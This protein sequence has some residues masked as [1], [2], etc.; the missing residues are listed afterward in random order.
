MKFPHIQSSLPKNKSF[1]ILIFWIRYWCVFFLLLPFILLRQVYI[2]IYQFFGSVFTWNR[3]YSFLNGK[4]EVLYMNTIK[5]LLVSMFFGERFLSIRF[6]GKVIDPGPPFAKQK[7]LEWLE[8]INIKY[9]LD[10]V[11][12][13]HG[14][15]EH[16]GNAGEVSDFFKIPIFTS[17]ISEK[18]IINPDKLSFV[19]TFFIGQPQ[20][21]KFIF[22][23]KIEDGFILNDG[24][25]SITSDGH[26]LGHISFYDPINKILFAGD[27]FLHEIFT[28]PNKES[29]AELWIATLEKYTQLDIRVMI[30][31]HG[32]V[33]TLDSQ[34]KNHL[35]VLEKKDPNEMIRNK[36][37]F[38]NWAVEIV[39]EGEKRGLSYKI[40]EACLFPWSYSWSWKNWFIDEGARFFSGGEFS[41]T[42]F[43]RSLASHPEKVPHRFFKR[44]SS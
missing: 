43:L 12:I 41:R 27:S 19:R 24:V 2:I 42:Q 5:S 6:H 38:I 14:H 7:V 18:T 44:S 17:A 40:I 22:S 29:K 36:L 31:S 32:Y 1:E 30:G 3:S 15:E 25:V 9:Q 33:T 16:I 21:R 8:K 13:T 20:K 28:S 37:N 39:K 10:G 34:Y 35:F 11:L 23:K 4:L 26:C